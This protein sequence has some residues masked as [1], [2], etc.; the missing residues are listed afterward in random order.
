MAWSPD[1]ESVYLWME[2]KIKR[3]DVASEQVT[4]VP[5]RVQATMQVAE[6]IRSEQPVAPDLVDIKMLRS[7]TVSPDGDR[8]AYVALG[9]IWVKKLPDGEPRRLTSLK[10]SYEH[11]PSFSRD[12]KS[13]VFCTWNDSELG[14]IRIASASGGNGRVITPGPGHYIDPIFSPDGKTIVFRQTGGGYLRSPLFSD[15]RGLFQISARGGEP[16]LIREGGYQAQFGADNDRLYYMTTDGDET[17]D[18][19]ML[20]VYDFEKRTERTLYTSDA[21]Q[22]WSV[23]PDGNWLAFREGFNVFITPMIEAGRTVSIG[24]EAKGLPVAKVTKEAGQNLSWSGDSQSLNWSLGATLYERDLTD[25]FAYL[26]G[27]PEELPEPPVEGVAIG[28]TA[29]PDL[30][31]GITALT[32][33][34]IITMRGEEVIE[35]GVIVI[36][37]NKV[38]TVGKMGDVQIPR[39][40]TIIDSSGKT[41]I[42][43]L[44]DAH[45]HG[46]QGTSGII[47]QHNWSQYANLAFGVTTIHDPSNSTEMIFSASEMQRTGMIRAPR[48]FSTGTILYG[49]AGVDYHAEIN[50]LDDA[51]FHLKR[52]QAVGAFSVKSYNQP[53][54]DQRQQVLEAARQLN[55]LVVPE[56]GATLMANLTMV[57]DGHTTVE[58]NIPVETLYNDVLQ[59]W[60]AGETAN[61]PT[62]VVSYGGI[63]GENY[64]YQHTDVWKHEALTNFVPR[65]V[66]DSRSRRRTMAP[67]GDYNHIKISQSLKKLYDRDVL[68]NIGAHGQLAGLAAHWEM[69]M[70]GQGGMTPME[71]LRCATM[72][73]A[74]TLGL[75]REIGSLEPGK[76]ADLVILNDNPLE[77]IRNTDSVH[78]VMLNGRLYD[79]STMDQIG[80]HPDNIGSDAFG[81]GSNSIGIGQWWGVSESAAHTHTGCSCGAGG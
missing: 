42:P 77:N 2:G 18:T 71:V 49:A 64:W 7:V 23:S 51:L 9:H 34:R 12:G 68:I 57:V 27:A 32:N 24:A 30:P 41:I 10:E 26:D 74:L 8:V 65:Y 38:V 35:D 62:L 33:A 78:S 53:R 31:E 21:V 66:V 39:G 3:L 14:E 80:A 13:I 1:S 17:S 22:A 46:A 75:D 4:A 44:I 40:A 69:W 43:G 20:D 25:S 58:H 50:S 37:G 48:I 63:S 59:L 19:R 60:E 56:G 76:L 55:M 72:N 36:D 61:T 47:P 67:E 81:D 45:A 6:V 5:F 11:D 16:E 29:S 15:D 54:R 52:M 70:L 79:A 73:P 28:F